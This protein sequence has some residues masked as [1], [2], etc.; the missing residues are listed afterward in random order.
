[1]DIRLEV[2]GPSDKTHLI[3]DLCEIWPKLLPSFLYYFRALRVRI[4]RS[5]GRSQVGPHGKMDSTE[6]WILM[7]LNVVASKH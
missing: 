7:A 2:F 6:K 1:M 4:L 5:T 3:R